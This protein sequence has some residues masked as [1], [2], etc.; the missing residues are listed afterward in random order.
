[1]GFVDRS[2]VCHQSLRTLRERRWIVGVIWREIS[3]GY[4]RSIHQGWALF[5]L[6]QHLWLCLLLTTA[7]YAKEHHGGKNH[8]RNNGT[9]DTTNDKPYVRSTSRIVAG[10]A[11]GGGLSSRGYGGD[12]TWGLFRVPSDA[13]QGGLVVRLIGGRRYVVESPARNGSSSRD[14]FWVL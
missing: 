4:G 8:E 14:G 11:G 6:I 5:V 7:S 9:D 1:M 13:H 10:I 2:D 3:G 12:H